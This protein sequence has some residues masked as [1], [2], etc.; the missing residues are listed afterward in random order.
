MD[1][2]KQTSPI[3]VR[4]LDFLGSRKKLVREMFSKSFFNNETHA[5]FE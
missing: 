5:I 2:E 4:K 3:F 1:K